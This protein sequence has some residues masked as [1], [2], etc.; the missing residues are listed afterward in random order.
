VIEVQR[1][2]KHYGDRLAVD[3]V[4][5]SVG[6][7]EVVGFVGP[8][9]AGKTTTMRVLT[10]YLMPTSGE[11][12]IAGCDM[13]GNS[14]CAR[15]LIGYLPEMAPS[16]AE[17][18][19]NAFLAFAARL[20]GFD[21]K[22]TRART[23]EVVE[24]L[25]IEDYADVP[26]RKLS[27]GYRQRVGLAQA[28]V[29]DPQVLILDEPTAGIDPIQIVETK[30]LI[31]EFGKTRTVLLSS[32]ILS[33]VSAIS[34]RVIVMNAGRIVAEDR[35]ENLSAVLR[36]G[37]RLRLTVRGPA[38]D[39]TAALLRIEGIEEVRFEAPHHLI[40]FAAG[41][42]PQA[43]IAKVVAEA[44]WTLIAMEVLEMSLEDIFL[45]LTVAGRDEAA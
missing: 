36:R 42:E 34:D 1:L 25:Q 31:A 29:H 32:H 16:Y 2:T 13:I 9:G 43:A 20:R 15:R 14:L 21:A 18:T 6:K 45:Q 23:A 27:K 44:G 22:Q 33:D 24:A 19:P 35:I 17:M 39:V 7:G 10:G 41:E 30:R 3:D 28:I 4:S 38:G 40:D 12:R 8:N 37:G 5:F 26:I 11:V